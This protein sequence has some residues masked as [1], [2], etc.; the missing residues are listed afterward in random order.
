MLFYDT[1]T[2]PCNQDNGVKLIDP[3]GE[4]L[5]AS[6]EAHATTL[7]NARSTEELINIIQHIVDT[8]NIDITRPAIVIYGRDTRPTGD[9]LVAALQDGIRAA[10][11]EGRDAG[12]TT[13]PIVHY[14]VR[15]TNSKDFGEPT[16]TGYYKKMTDAF[17]KLVVGI[18][19]MR[20]S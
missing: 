18:R 4:M 10:G 13:T 8:I 6:W 7:A 12:I 9:L 15:A 2:Q 5:E 14:L 20:H 1:Y 11:A 16:E 17:K 19:Y 3:R